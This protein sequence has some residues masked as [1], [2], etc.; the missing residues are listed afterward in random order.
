LVSTDDAV[1]DSLD[2]A[3]STAKQAL[4]SYEYALAAVDHAKL[5]AREHLI[6][7]V[8]AQVAATQA[9]V[10][11]AAWHLQQARL[12]APVTGMVNNRYY[13]PGEWV[14]AYHSVLSILAKKN[15]KALFFVPEANLSQMRI[16][17]VVWLG[18]SGRKKRIAAEV[19]YISPKAEYT[20][21]VIYSQQSKSKL[22]YRIE[23]AIKDPKVEV[24]PGQ[25]IA[26]T[27][28]EQG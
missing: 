11:K 25:V 6:A 2:A 10:S 26:V 22:V 16:H 18:I 1:Q 4:A 23:A 21:P 13:L 14:N 3:V 7:A 15:I 19:R 28:S 12:I 5:P 24:H 9:T 27:L 8:K 20:P 17:Q